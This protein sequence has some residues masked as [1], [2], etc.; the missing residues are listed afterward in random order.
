MKNIS[1]IDLTE[2]INSYLIEKD[3][4]V[5][6]CVI[7]AGGNPEKTIDKEIP[8][9]ALFMV[10]L[11]PI[12]HRL[13][14]DL[15]ANALKTVLDIGPSSFG[16]TAL[17]ANLHAKQSFNRLKLNVSAVD[18]TA[19]YQLLQKIVA[20]NIDF[21]VCDVFLIKNRVWDFVVCSHV[22]EHVHKPFEFLRQLQSLAKDFVLV[23]CPWAERP[24][25]CKSHINIIEEDFIAAAGGRDL[26]TYVNYSW[27][28]KR[29]VCSFWLPGYADLD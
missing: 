15:P 4:L 19:R 16:G 26:C 29:N 7:A 9:S 23:S 18:I 28:K 5:R 10:E 20:P 13:Y 24:L 2:R 17:L 1:E 25:T 3:E 11:I 12:I 27:G 21:F 8:Q 14:M 6:D 22:I